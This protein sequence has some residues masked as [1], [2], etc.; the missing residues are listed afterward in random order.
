MFNY[1][2]FVTGKATQAKVVKDVQV[3]LVGDSGLNSTGRLEV[4]YK[5]VWGTVCK[6]NFDK[7]DADVICRQLGFPYAISWDARSYGKG[8]G[9]I[10]LNDVNCNGRETSIAS[11]HH[12]GWGINKCEHKQD[13][14]LTCYDSM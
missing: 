5:G 3:R 2:F 12:N 8:F 10:W 7:N 4:L 1:V 9:K 13:A 14:G 6:Y 11:C